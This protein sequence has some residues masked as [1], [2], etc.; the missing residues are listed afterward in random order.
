MAPTMEKVK[1]NPGVYRRGGRYFVPYR[2]P[3]SKKQRWPSFPTFEAAR[4]FKRS[5]AVDADRGE[6]VQ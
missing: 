4:R 2:E 3:G 1:K 6:H 5:Q